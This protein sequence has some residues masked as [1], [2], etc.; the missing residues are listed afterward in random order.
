MGATNSV[1]ANKNKPPA[2]RVV[3]AKTVAAQAPGPAVAQVPGPAV[4]QYDTEWINNWKNRQLLVKPKRTNAQPPQVL[5]VQEE[6]IVPKIRMSLDDTP[7]EDVVGSSDRCNGYDDILGLISGL[8]I[9]AMVKSTMLHSY[10]EKKPLQECAGRPAPASWQEWHKDII[11][12]MVDEGIRVLPGAQRKEFVFLYRAQHER[13]ALLARFLTD[14]PNPFQLLPSV[15][16]VLSTRLANGIVL[17][18]MYGY[19]W[20]DI[21]AW[22]AHQVLMMF[23]VVPTPTESSRTKYD[24]SRKAIIALIKQN[25]TDLLASIVEALK[26]ELQ[27]IVGT[28]LKHPPQSQD[29]ATF[30]TSS[31]NN[32]DEG[33]D[34]SPPPLPPDVDESPKKDAAVASPYKKAIG[35]RIDSRKASRSVGVVVNHRNDTKAVPRAEVEDDD[36]E[37]IIGISSSIKLSR[38]K[39]PTRRGDP[40]PEAERPPVRRQTKQTTKTGT[41]RISPAAAATRNTKRVRDNNAAAKEGRS[42][43][44]TPAALSKNPK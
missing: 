31:P 18:M 10:V 30:V 6:V 39:P 33:D 42:R 32:K 3:A 35:T 9:V 44:N 24:A 19:R 20:E 34:A 28:K 1:P 36:D 8:K 15:G 13:E 26:I 23:P 25:T 40:P 11:K 16:P 14:N 12:A 4:A 21:Q 27:K 17:G 41:R 37:S 22:C 5:F 2:S 29:L 43:N 7:V 38:R